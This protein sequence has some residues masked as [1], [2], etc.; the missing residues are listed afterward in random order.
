MPSEGK[1]PVLVATHGAGG[2]PEAHCG[3]WRALLHDRAVVLCPRGV[4]MDV[5]APPEERG[6]FYSNHPALERELKDA[7]AALAARFPDR[8]DLDRAVYAGYS[9]GA[10]MG[11][12]AIAPSPAPFA[13]VV[14]V[15]GG[16]DAWSG[17]SAKAFKAGGGERVLFACGRQSC[18]DGA[19]RSASLLR[20]AGVEVRVVDASGAGHTHDGAVKAGLVKALPWLLDG[21]PR[22]EVP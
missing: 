2:T 1:R 20:R 13:T 21:D 12:L 4:T 14:L 19:R 3:Y 11:A 7:I 10:T 8:V 6:Y 5:Y 15:E 18:A 22:F 16:S 17:R 9:Q